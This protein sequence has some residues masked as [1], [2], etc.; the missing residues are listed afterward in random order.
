MRGALQCG[1]LQGLTLLATTFKKW[2]KVE[3]AQQHVIVYSRHCQKQPRLFP[4]MCSHCS[5][6]TG[7]KTQ[8]GYNLFH[9]SPSPFLLS[10]PFYLLAPS[11]SS[12]P[13]RTSTLLSTALLQGIGPGRLFKFI[14]VSKPALTSVPVQK[15]RQCLLPCYHL[16]ILLAHLYCIERY[17][18]LQSRC[19]VVSLAVRDLDVTSE[20]WGHVFSIPLRLI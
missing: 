6:S 4:E 19:N 9:Y 17:F 14:I 18:G 15:A 20:K 12:T 10:A 16:A 11:L 2:K 5:P 8:P 7:T 1:W 13:S 3:K